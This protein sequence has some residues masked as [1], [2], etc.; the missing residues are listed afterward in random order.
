MI[1][2]SPMK[3]PRITSQERDYI[4]YEISAYQLTKMA[5]TKEKMG[6]SA[7]PSTDSIDQNKIPWKE[8]LTSPA[9]FAV[10]LAHFTSNWGN[11]QM[12]TLL[13]TY[14]DSVLQ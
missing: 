11:Y 3:H 8:I 4:T 1:H 6:G 9:V 2:D 5:E 12:N 14:L 10:S 13:P 7:P